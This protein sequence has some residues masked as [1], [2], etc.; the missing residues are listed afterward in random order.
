MIWMNLKKT[1]LLKN[2][3]RKLD[4]E[5]L[6]Q[7]FG[8]KLQSELRVEMDGE[9]RRIFVQDDFWRLEPLKKFFIENPDVAIFAWQKAGQ[10]VLPLDE[11]R[12]KP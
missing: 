2:Q 12:P 1:K 7:A 6:I 9:S 10:V 5:I 3:Q 11:T 8:S 4:M